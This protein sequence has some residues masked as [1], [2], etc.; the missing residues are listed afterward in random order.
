[1]Y[2][3]CLWIYLSNALK[4][5]QKKLHYYHSKYALGCPK[6]LTVLVIFQVVSS[7]DDPTALRLDKWGKISHFIPRFPHL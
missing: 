4:Q 6:G 7:K 5:K 1:M 3:S 2:S